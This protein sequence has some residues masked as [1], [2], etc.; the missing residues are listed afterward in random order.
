MVYPVVCN[1]KPT[2]QMQPARS[3]AIGVLSQGRNVAERDP[4]TSV[5]NR[6]S[7]KTWEMWWIPDVDG[8]A[9]TLNHRKL[10]Q[11]S[12]KKQATIENQKN[13]E[14]GPSFYI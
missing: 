3:G 1:V 5:G 13:A 8:C 6:H 11:K 2:G 9:K 12:A 14:W 4:L 10:L 7:E